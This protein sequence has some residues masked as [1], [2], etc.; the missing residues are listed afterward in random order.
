[1][2][3][4]KTSLVISAIPFVV[5][6]IVLSYLVQTARGEV[7]P[8]VSYFC[9][10]LAFIFAMSTLSYAKYMGDNLVRLG[11]FITLGADYFLVLAN[12]TRELAGVIV[13]CF[14]QLA[15]F[16]ALILTDPCQRRRVAHVILRVS[17][18]ALVVPVTLLVVG[19]GVDAL[20][21]FSAMYYA[22]L[23]LNALFAFLDYKRWWLFGVGLVAFALCDASIGFTFLANE[24]LGATEGSF[25]YAVANSDL[26][27]AW[28]FYVP[29]Q[30][31]IALVP[32]F[33]AFSDVRVGPAFR[34]GMS[35]REKPSAE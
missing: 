15:Y 27:L 12:P 5:A 3:L 34:L 8:A 17:V 7:V 1:M 22:N 18:T 4:N 16:A 19:E 25:L 32:L 26:N 20:A 31:I 13:F 29:S 14:V 11:L 33:H 30:A 21:I 23:V 24:Y 28:V 2:K 9:V 10:L 35:G 6:E